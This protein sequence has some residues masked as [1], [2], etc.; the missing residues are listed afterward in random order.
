MALVNLDF[1]DQPEESSWFSGWRRKLFPLRSRDHLRALPASSETGLRSRINQLIKQQLGWIPEGDI[2]LLTGFGFLAHRFNPVSFY[3]CL[4]Q[5]GQL[6]C[7]VAEVT[8]TPW[9]EQFYYV[10]DARSQQGQAKLTF[11]CDKDFH[12]SPFMPMDTQYR[13]GLQFGDD[14]LR[15][16]IDIDRQQSHCFSATLAMT[17]HEFTLR[18]FWRCLLQQPL[19]SL[20]VVLA[21]HWQALRLWLKSTPFF[22]HPKKSRGVS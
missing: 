14:S 13:W 22:I 18:N 3:F 7:L 9:Q 21:I 17:R 19:M 15:L 5:S 16:Q 11:A 12:V 1:L 2:Y 10:L 6:A 20:Q 8:N 4:D